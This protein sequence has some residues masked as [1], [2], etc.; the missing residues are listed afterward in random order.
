MSFSAY[1]DVGLNRGPQFMYLFMNGGQLP[2]SMW[3][4]QINSDAFDNVVG[5]TISRILVSSLLD[6]VA[7]MLPNMKC[8]QIL[9]LDAGDTLE[10]R[11]IKG[12]Y[13]SSITLNIELIGL[14]FDYICLLYTSPSPRDS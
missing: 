8:L 2:E 1:G 4:C 7:R 3:H 11:I 9:H 10:L 12:H 5:F 6:M 14:G 13:I